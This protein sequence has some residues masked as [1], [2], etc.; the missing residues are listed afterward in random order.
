VSAGCGGGCGG[1]DLEIDDLLSVDFD[2]PGSFLDSPNA[3]PIVGLESTMHHHSNH[4]HLGCLVGHDNGGES[5][6]DCVD[7]RLIPMPFALRNGS[8]S[9][10]GIGVRRA[11]IPLAC[12]ST[13]E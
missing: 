9:Q 7:S 3:N 12:T 2:E 5:N 10:T 4:A 13:Q 8:E 6:A 11:T 1:N